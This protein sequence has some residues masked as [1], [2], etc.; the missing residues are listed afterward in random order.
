MFTGLKIIS[1]FGKMRVLH[2][3]LLA[4]MRSSTANWARPVQSCDVRPSDLLSP[5]GRTGDNIS[6][7]EDDLSL[8]LLNTSFDQQSRYLSQISIFVL[9]RVKT[10]TNKPL[11]TSRDNI[12]AGVAE[13]LSLLPSLPIYLGSVVL[14]CSLDRRWKSRPRKATAFRM[15]NTY[16]YIWLSDVSLFCRYT[17]VA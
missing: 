9:A 15:R 16:F 1:V 10:E 6:R 13:S 7:T 14:Y 2:I 17:R 3:D 12:E 4:A 11:S 8:W 5:E